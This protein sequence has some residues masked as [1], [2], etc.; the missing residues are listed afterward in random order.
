MKVSKPVFI[1]LLLVVPLLN[2]QLQIAGEP[3]IMAPHAPIYIEGNSNFTAANGVVGG[4]GTQADPFI[5]QNWEIECSS[6]HGIWIANTTLYFVIRN[7]RIHSQ[8][9][10][11]FYG[12]YLINLTNARIE[13]VTVENALT[14]FAVFGVRNGIFS[15]LYASNS[16]LGVNFFAVEQS[17]LRNSIFS[18]NMNAACVLTASEN[19]Q[20]SS[21]QIKN[22]GVRLIGVN[23]SSL[24]NSHF[25]TEEGIG[26]ST[27]DCY[28]LSIQNNVFQ[29]CSIFLIGDEPWAYNSHTIT[30]NTVNGKEILYV[31]NQA[32]QTI[33]GSYGEIILASTVDSTIS[34][35]VMSGGD[36]LIEI[37]DCQRI[38]INNVSL[39]SARYGIYALSSTSLR[40]RNIFVN[41]TESGIVGVDSLNL[42]VENS[43]FVSAG[44]GVSL[45]STTTGTISYSVFENGTFGVMSSQSTNLLLSSLDFT[46]N[47]QAVSFIATQSSHIRDSRF[48]KNDIGVKFVNSGN[49]TITRNLFMGTTHYAITLDGSSNNNTISQNAF[50]LNHNGQVQC[51]DNGGNN[52]WYSGELG[53]FWDDWTTPD[54]NNDSIVD[55][56]Y[57]LDGQAQAQDNYPL[58]LSPLPQTL[59]L[60]W[61]ISSQ[62]V[63][64]NEYVSFTIQVSCFETGIPNAFLEYFPKLGDVSAQNYTNENGMV[65]GTYISG[66]LSG[67]ENLTVKITRPGFITKTIWIPIHIQEY[68]HIQVNVLPASSEVY[69]EENTT[70][71][72]FIHT[73]GTPV[74]GAMVFFSV[75]PYAM[76]SESIKTT[77]ADGS[78][79]VTVTFPAVENRTVFRVYVNASKT[80]YLDGA[81]WCDIYVNP[82]KSFEMNVSAAEKVVANTTT[83]IV[84]TVK[85][86]N[87]A[88]A[89]V[90]ISLSSDM[91]CNFTPLSGITDTNGRFKSDIRMPTVEYTTTVKIYIHAW[92]QGY[93]S[94]FLEVEIIV[95]NPPQRPMGLTAEGLDRKVVL[96]WNTSTGAKIYYIY[97]SE[98]QGGDYTLIGN[99][100]TEG[101]EDTDV[102]NGHTY[103]YKVQAGNDFGVSEWSNEVGV[104]P[105]APS[106]ITPGFEVFIWMAVV[107]IALLLPL[108]KRRT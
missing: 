91:A 17:E 14:G 104:T 84:I 52:R 96:R 38:N 12:I 1:G 83:T 30:G 48:I 20:L 54:A 62:E 31:K 98:T 80:G 81:G 26:L 70:V 75:E 55:I 37:A 28:A 92:K 85:S 108:R 4:S 45:V 101:Y 65:S 66:N 102:V 87:T 24:S 16:T 61:Y 2:S 64:T 77:D 39:T 106:K 67:E 53:N 107:C 99:S 76:L 50:L 18:N 59:S 51:S 94:S 82:L 40:L 34:S 49:T 42:T 23:N 78:A 71:V 15:S 89:N 105:H 9:H 90:N 25:E 41:G 29:N 46:F 7:V 33:S 35:A 19:I 63:Y 5:I 88:L 97:R 86:E 72:A 27:E 100:T 11:S 8:N 22:T 3:E 60:E 74:E 93:T 58:V 103:Y 32:G 56:P 44:V 10:S 47:T 43:R 6:T 73:G 57:S 36:V 68:P 69:G 21:L 79:E 13:N 95:G